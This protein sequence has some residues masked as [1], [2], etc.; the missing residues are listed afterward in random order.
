[1]HVIVIVGIE[2][3]CRILLFFNHATLPQCFSQVNVSMNMNVSVLVRKHKNRI[4]Q[5]LTFKKIKVLKV[6]QKPL[7]VNNQNMITSV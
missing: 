2:P 6:D 1:M 7:L 5:Y 4:K 3:D